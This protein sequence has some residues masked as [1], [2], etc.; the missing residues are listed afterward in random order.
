MA[1]I[2]IYSP[3]E[4]GKSMAGAAI[5][6]WEFAK[7]LAAKHQTVLFAQNVSKVDPEQFEILAFHDPRLKQHFRDADIL[8]TQRLTLSLAVLTIKHRLKIIIDAYVPRPLELL[9][10]MKEA[11]S[12]EVFNS[13]IS[14]L[15]LSFK[16][17]DGILC[18]TERQRALWIGFLLG[19]KLLS[20][21]LY[22]RDPSLRDFL[23]LV[24]FG[25]SS[26]APRKTGKGLKEK[27]RLK[28]SDHVI[29]W[30]GGI[31]DWF[32]PLTLIHA[33]HLIQQKRSDIKLV[34]MG[35]TPP[36][37]TLPKTSLSA[38]VIQLAERLSLVN[39]S[40]F[41][42]YDWI[43][44]EERQNFLVEATLGASTHFDHLETTFSFR[45]RILDY[46]WANLP[47]L[48]TEGDGF[49]DL[50]K[51]NNLGIVVPY[52]NAEAI[53]HG[54]LA[55]FDE[56]NKLLTMQKNVSQ[57]KEQ[58]YWSKVSEPLQKMVDRLCTAPYA[59][60]RWKEGKAL[61]AFLIQKIKTRLFI[62]GA[63]IFQVL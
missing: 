38:K 31:W 22:A 51:Q 53:A 40:V 18:A 46:L 55:I 44:Y 42:N 8:I 54:L 2:L 47:I 56:P 29:I 57:L 39:Q 48:T 30:G 21:T 41:F 26:I 27:F 59:R 36:D 17:A 28:E 37:P 63:R 61:S 52:Q 14:N 15:L 34:F 43:P 16:M 11:P 4:I 32:D 12:K 20:P 7:I 25:L 62:K 60:S 1:K 3:N 35:I 9:E 49:A 5:R 50:I 19:Q 13:E 58:F 24:P 6:S 45:T 33:M 23:A 10:H